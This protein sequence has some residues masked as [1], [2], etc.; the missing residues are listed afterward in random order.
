MNE[1]DKEYTLPTEIDYEM[2]VKSVPITTIAFGL[3][4]FAFA[5]KTNTYIYEPL[6]FLWWI[7]NVIIGVS[8]SLETASNG[9]KRLWQSLILYIF[10]KNQ[11]Y[12]SISDPKEYRQMKVSEKNETP[13]E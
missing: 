2:N 9:K 12:C 4:F 1:L 13:D 6:Q 7:F 8:L 11:T 10:G 3:I 5:N